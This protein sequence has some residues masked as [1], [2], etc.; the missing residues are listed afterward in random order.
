MEAGLGHKSDEWHL[1][2]NSSKLNL[3]MVGASTLWE[4]LPI[5]FSHIML[6]TWKK[7]LW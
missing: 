7:A 2:T 4:H 3:N 1:F 5:Y 6:I